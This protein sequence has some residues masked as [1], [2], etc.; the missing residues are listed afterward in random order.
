MM[1]KRLAALPMP[2]LYAPKQF[3]IIGLIMGES[4]CIRHLK[5]L[6]QERP[7]CRHPQLQ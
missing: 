6:P 7:E 5:L 3:L 1:L 4:S 2:L